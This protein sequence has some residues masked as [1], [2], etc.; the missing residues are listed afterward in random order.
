MGYDKYYNARD[1][2][3]EIIS[4]DL[5]GPVEDDEII[6][7]ESPLEYYIVGKLYPKDADYNN[8]TTSADDC[9][10]L[11]SEDSISLCNGKFPSSFGLSFCVKNNAKGFLLSV[12]AAKYTIMTDDEK[13]T[14]YGADHES[15]AA[16]CTHWKRTSITPDEICIDINELPLGSNKK[17]ELETGLYIAIH[18]HKVFKNGDKII[19]VSMINAKMQNGDYQKGSLYAYFQPNI[20]IKEIEKNSFSPLEY[21][22]SL[23]SDPE[24]IELDMLYR[25]EKRYVSGH[26]CAANSKTEDNL[27]ALYSDFLPQIELL[28]MKPST[29]F[30]G[31]ILAMKALAEMNAQEII[32]GLSALTS[33]Y[34]EWIVLQES[35]TK[36][37]DFMYRNAAKTNLD[38]CRQTL[39]RINK[40]IEALKDK[41][42]FRAFQLAN[43]VML[44]QRKDILVRTGRYVSD[45]K[46]TWYPFQ[47]AFF[48]QEIISFADESSEERNLADLLWFPTGGGKTEAYLGISAFVIFLRRLRYKNDGVGVSVIMRYTMRLLTF[49]QFERASSMICNCELVRK[50]E[51]IP[52][53]EISIGLWVGTALTPNKLVDA[54]KI[55]TG[56]DASYQNY[57]IGNPV[58][59]TKCPYCGE[60][61]LNSNYRCDMNLKRMIITCPSSDCPFHNGLP[62]YLIDEEI[63]VHKP[64]YI[65]A[66]IDKFAQMAVNEECANLFGKDD[67]LP[68]S[69]I[70]QDELHLISG[71]LGTITGLYEAAIQKI[72]TKNGKKPKVIASTATIK[73]A[74]EQI[75]A[76]YGSKHTQFPPQAINHNDSFF[77]EISTRNER[78]AR[79]YMGCMAIGTSPTTMMIRTMASE[80][81][82]SRYLSEQTDDDSVIDSYWTITGYFNTLRELG[83]AIVRVIDDIQDRFNYLQNTKFK[84]IYRMQLLNQRYTKYKE[85]TSR[86]KSEDIG[87]I[88]QQE[89]TIPFK[90]DGS[91]NPYDFILSSNM[92]SVGV[93]VSRLGIMQVVGQPKTTAEYIQA[94]SRVGRENPGLVITTY[95]QAKS[96]DRSH[97]EQFY[98]YHSSFY[99]FVESTSITPFSDR[100]RDRV[101]QT[102]YV[103]LCRY[104]IPKLFHDDDAVN[105]KKDMPELVAIR[106]YIYDYVNKVDPG[107]LENVKYEISMIEEEWEEKRG[108]NNS[109]KYRINS[110]TNN[111]KCLFD[112]DYE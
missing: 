86:E 39:C 4:K 72:C 78:P 12:S 19:T 11:D 40:S 98:P 31:K 92:I 7:G 83:G 91:T 32:A 38:K 74:A 53:G 68:P 89:L 97:Y 103:I 110:H 70:I 36:E 88:I 60:A 22:T 35:Y 99:K 16:K 52:G 59:I 15:K 101:L 67:V 1:I 100:A 71:P 37:N 20:T 34:D 73:N 80:L 96:R 10:D 63:Y 28:Q 112:P 2:L 33:A 18:I 47:L 3:T 93:D 9:G 21:K 50:A 56:R 25:N 81:F 62:V 105:Y 43:K 14:L 102:L 64:T 65:V 77:A 85:L 45:E 57:T 82:A 87:K 84:K 30:T 106:N 8:I 44:N 94:T 24:L 58:Q 104:S 111:E 46:I 29:R 109:F 108:R 107:E 69:L 48:I 42:V 51:N 49:Q 79:M 54:E 95:N 5:L 55:L 26:G 90:K 76:L 75:K 17:I 66:T 27:M 61:I 13:R 23:S 41:T 6:S